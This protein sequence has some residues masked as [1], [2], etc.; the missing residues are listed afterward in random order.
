MSSLRT[1]SSRY[2]SALA[3]AQEA[4]ASW[5]LDGTRHTACCDARQ[6]IRI[7]LFL[8]RYTSTQLRERG[9]R[10][11]AIVA[12]SCSVFTEGVT[13]WRPAATAGG[14]LRAEPVRFF[15]R[16]TFDFF[17]LFRDSC[18][19]G[20]AVESIDLRSTPCAELVAFFRAASASFS[21]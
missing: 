7:S 19:A 20:R 17:R 3:L 13:L 11:P 5:K 15:R 6:L 16:A 2:S 4:V 1:G 18:A 8:P 10:A 14:P 9:G 12:G 21:L